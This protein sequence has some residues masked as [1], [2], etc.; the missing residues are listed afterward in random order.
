M[1]IL[2][3]ICHSFAAQIACTF[4]CCCCCCCCV[5]TGSAHLF[6]SPSSKDLW[7]S[8]DGEAVVYSIQIVTVCKNEQIRQSPCDNH[9]VIRYNPQ[10][11]SNINVE[12]NACSCVLATVRRPLHST[13][14]RR[15]RYRLTRTD[16]PKPSLTTTDYCI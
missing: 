16:S 7:P 15:H 1:A 2:C 14:L 3:Q 5:L 6:K 8:I 12:T 10:S 11:S 9:I 4:N 13:Q